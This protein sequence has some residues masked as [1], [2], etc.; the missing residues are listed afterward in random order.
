MDPSRRQSQGLARAV[1]VD[2]KDPERLGRIKVRV[3]ASDREHEV[4]ARVTVPLGANRTG[5]WALPQVGDEVIVAFE[6]GEMRTPY[7]IG[8][9]WNGE[10]PPPSGKSS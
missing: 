6:H 4:W 9:L 5:L 8:S 3:A 7:V 2:L 10:D 1:V